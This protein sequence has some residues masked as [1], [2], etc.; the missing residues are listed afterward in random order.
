MQRGKEA[1]KQR[2]TMHLC[3]YAPMRLSTIYYLLFTLLSM[4]CFSLDLDTSIDDEIRK[5][6]NPN[7][8]EE[9]ME[10]P[11]LPKI[12]NEVSNQNSKPLANKSLQP[13]TNYSQ[14]QPQPQA[15]AQAQAHAQTPNLQPLPAKYSKPFAAKTSYATLKK[16]TK[17]P[18]ILNNNISD[19]T[20]KGTK[21]SLIS[22]YPVTTTYFT[23]PAGTIFYGEILDSHRP[24]LTGNGGL[25]VLNINKFVVDNQ[26]YSIDSD[27][28]NANYKKI[29][30]NNIKGKRKYI[31][32]T[33]KS[34]RPGFRYL[35]KMASVSGNLMQRGSTIILAPFS[36]A[37]GTLVAAGNV[38]ISPAL[39]LFHKGGSIGLK[40]GTPVEIVLLEDVFI[41]K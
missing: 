21:I 19:G 32:S 13:K 9:D 20:R 41:Y 17:I 31:N 35:G 3:T 25:L 6:Y 24:Q 18:L 12:F 15:Q 8:I 26:I 1:K 39:G 36:L 40:N 33:F 2:K 27:V 4:P 28:T 38:F 37:L 22:R 10:L 7:K 34:M 30:F 11:A 29:F 16:G 14:P 5:N 23:I